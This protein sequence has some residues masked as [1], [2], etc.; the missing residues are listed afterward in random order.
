MCVCEVRE[1]GSKV[2][3]QGLCVDLRGGGLLI[4]GLLPQVVA[5][6]VLLLHAVDEEEDE[7]HGEHQSHGAGD[8]SW[9]RPDGKRQNQTGQTKVENKNTSITFIILNLKSR[10]LLLL[11]IYTVFAGI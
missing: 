9:K 4:D 7:E 5:A 2:K 1:E 10:E 8:Q 11:Y 3:G 6:L